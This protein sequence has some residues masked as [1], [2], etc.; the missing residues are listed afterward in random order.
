MT[1]NGHSHSF[2]FLS[3]EI[4]VIRDIRVIRGEKSVSTAV[5]SGGHGVRHGGKP[6]R[7]S[8]ERRSRSCRCKNSGG[9]TFERGERV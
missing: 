9:A 8:S 3:Q 1:G 2:S 6:L 4:F 5:L 7:E